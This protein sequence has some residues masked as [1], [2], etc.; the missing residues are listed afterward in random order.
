LNQH[1]ISSEK[2]I[3]T[4][5]S[6]KDDILKKE[7]IARENL[8]SNKQNI[9][10]IRNLKMK[11][12]KFP[13]L[14]IIKADL[15]KFEIEIKDLEE[16]IKGLEQN[17]GNLRENEKEV[18][19][20]IQ[21]GKNQISQLQ[22]SLHLITS[23]ESEV[24]N[25]YHILETKK[26]KI[27]N[28]LKEL[29]EFIT[30]FEIIWLKNPEEES[31]THNLSVFKRTIMK[32]GDNLDLK[33]LEVLSTELKGVIITKESEINTSNEIEKKHLLELSSNETQSEQDILEFDKKIAQYEQRI[34]HLKNLES[35]REK[36][37]IFQEIFDKI[38]IQIRKN[39]SIAL[40]EKILDFHRILSV[41]D[42]FEKIKVDEENYSLSVKPKNVTNAEFYPASVYQGGGHKLILGLAYKLALG[43]LI[44]SPSF[45]LVDEPTEF[46]D[47]QNRINLLSNLETISKNAQ[48]LLI[49]HQDVD[50]IHCNQKILIKK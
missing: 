34:T 32:I 15:T 23:L 47:S 37:N 29:E 48:I 40:E 21:T 43:E 26:E 41:D 49:T 50:K 27:S 30:N 13:K 3:N 6:R 25:S 39:I 20:N 1:I 9:E 4:L 42:E 18:H 24:N 7:K 36:Y 44:G 17:L 46:M 33:D 5:K 45:L 12:N 2:E 11:L 16:N 8:T 31:F 10:I 19:T 28:I 22:D 35:F 38:Q 14:S